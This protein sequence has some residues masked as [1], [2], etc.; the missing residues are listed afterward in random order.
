[1]KKM[2]YIFLES[3]KEMPPLAHTTTKPFDITKSE[4][5]KW[6]VSQPEIMQKVFDMAANHKV[7]KYNTEKKTWQ[8]VDYD[9]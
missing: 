3:A 6:L 5:A 8:G 2:N 7:I 4:V 9:N 1:M